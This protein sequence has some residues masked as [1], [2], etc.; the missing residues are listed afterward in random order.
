[1]PPAAARSS[2]FTATNWGEL[3]DK[4]ERL[5]ALTNR[6]KWLEALERELANMRSNAAKELLLVS[7]RKTAGLEQWQINLLAEFSLEKLKKAKGDLAGMM[8]EWDRLINIP[9]PLE[10]EASAL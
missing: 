1:M 9:L 2:A 4:V 8:K 3:G 10:G 5:K 7:L 6:M